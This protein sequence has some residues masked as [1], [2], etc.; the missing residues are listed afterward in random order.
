MKK[1]GILLLGLFCAGVTLAEVPDWENPKVFRINKE[2]PRAT[3]FPFAS[4][5]EALTFDKTKSPYVQ[6]LNGQWKFHFAKNPESRPA[7]FYKTDFDISQWAEIAVPGNWQVQGYD[8]PIYTNI[9][10]PF[11]ADPPNVPRDYNPVGSYKTTFVVPE[12]WDGRNV[13]LQF[14]GVGTAAYIWVNGEKVGYTQDSRTTAEFNVTPYIRPGE[15]QLAVEVY[16]Y[17]DGSYLECQDFW[18]LS[19]IFRNVWLYAASPTQIRDFWAKPELDENYENAE[20]VVDLDLRKLSGKAKTVKAKAIL[21]GDQEL[22]AESDWLTVDSEAQTTVKIPVTNPKKWTAETP[23]LYPLVVELWDDENNLLDVT[24]IKIGFRKVEIRNGQLLVNGK[25]V[26]IRGVNRHEHDPDTAHYVREDT[27]IQDIL[28]M[29]QHNFNAVRT[30]HYPDCPRWYELCDEY[31]LFLTDE[32]NVESHGMGYGEKS[33]AKNP[34]WK[35]A[36]LDRN[37][38]MVERDKNHPSVIVWSLGNE[39]GDGDNFTACANWIRNRDRSRPVHYE[40][41]QGGANTDIVC[42]M[43][44]NPYYCRDYGSKEQTK[45]LIMCEYAHAMG[46]STGNFDLFWDFAFD[47][48]IKHYQGGYIWDWVDQGIRTAIPAD[49]KMPMAHHVPATE[50]AKSFMA[51][52]GD[53]GYVGVPSDDNFCCNG[54]ISSDRTEHPGLE[55]VK[56]CQQPVK[57]TLIS[58]E[59]GILKLNVKNRFDFIDLSDLQMQWRV[60]NL[61]EPVKID[62]PNLPAQESGEVTIDISSVKA[63]YIT[64]EFVLRNNTPWANAGH[65]VAVDQFQVTEMPQPKFTLATDAVVAQ[66]ETSVTLQKGDVSYT[67]C[68]TSGKLVSWKKGETELLAE[69]M[70]PDFWRAVTDNDRGNHAPKR[71]AI[72]KEAA[73]SWTIE[74]VNVEPGMVTFIGKLPNVQASL[75]VVFKVGSKGELRVVLEYA[76]EGENKLPEMPRL[77]MALALTP[78]FENF[79]WCGRGPQESYWDRKNGM[80]FGH[81]KSTVTENFF[82]YSEPQETGNHIDTYFLKLAG[83]KHSVQVFGVSGY[84]QKPW[85]SFNAL[86]FSTEDLE[87]HKHP[88]QLPLRE[89]TFLHIDY[90]QTGVGGN[91]SWGAQ[92][93]PQFKLTEKAY[94]FEF[95]M[96]VQ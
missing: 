59:N 36:H 53:F 55:Q 7:D 12:N 84:E 49:G 37:I 34:D 22:S 17:S 30:C 94:R 57:T 41:A 72:W 92:P 65:V 48:A 69:P 10:Y 78:G 46:N 89:E 95:Q 11:K 83:E 90:L 61:S 60:T 93:L 25:V 45:P 81:W 86:H 74:K 28:L 33:L 58:L 8:Y 82:P 19:G 38:N 42:P 62:C 68:K 70:Q 1:T 23:N 9:P 47:P 79:K 6:S 75:D 40:R 2:K 5:E 15:N 91:D 20:L 80:L 21:L 39:A 51:Y 73:K 43:Y 85:F 16:R 14:E 71:L 87:S 31:G 29:K 24:A 66:E 67:F 88:W 64:V 4:R 27:M 3:F 63:K 52:G 54:L 44:P 96:N 76:H 56:F 32:A 26:H 77:G 13:F 18:R 50:A 35:E